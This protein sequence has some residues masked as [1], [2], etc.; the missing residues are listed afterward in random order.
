MTNVEPTPDVVAAHEHC[1]NHRTE[2]AAST[3][4]GCFH[5][6]RL[7]A[8]GEIVDWID[9][10]PEMVEEVGRPGQ[11]ARCPRCGIDAVIGDRCGF[12]ITAVFLDVMRAHWF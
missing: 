3:V 9:P 7:F 1:S 11:T 6:C 2:L 10:A 5:C 4:C 8:P 12:P